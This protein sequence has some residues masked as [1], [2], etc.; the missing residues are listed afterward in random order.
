MLT[1]TVG[2]WL[3]SAFSRESSRMRPSESLKRL[4]PTTLVAAPARASLGLAATSRARLG[5]KTHGDAA[6]AR[7]V[8]CLVGR[9]HPRGDG[10]FGQPSG[11]GR[12]SGPP[13][14]LVVSARTDDPSRERKDSNKWIGRVKKVY[15]TQRIRYIGREKF[16]RYLPDPRQ[17]V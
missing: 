17:H 5:D 12:A 3:V 9:R 16:C 14:S 7:Q 10:F 15:R 6:G 13:G 2:L 1:R 11:A 8:G 4:S